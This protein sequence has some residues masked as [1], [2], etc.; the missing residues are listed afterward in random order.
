MLL[1][2][3]TADM[4]TYPAIDRYIGDVLHQV[5]KPKEGG[6]EQ[7]GRKIFNILDSELGQKKTSTEAKNYKKVLAAIQKSKILF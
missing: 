3:E 5:Y 1:K 2:F 6:N 4:K 7:L